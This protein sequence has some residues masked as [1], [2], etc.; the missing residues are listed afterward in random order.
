MKL[1]QPTDGITTNRGLCLASS[2]LYDVQARYLL[3]DEIATGGMAS[4]H[5]GRSTERGGPGSVVAIKQMHP[6]LARSAE[7]VAMFLDE[8]RMVARIRHPNVVPVV[9]VVLDGGQLL[10]VMKLVIGE[11]L[12]RLIAIVREPVPPPIAV[13]IV[14]DMLRGLHAA[15]E[16]TDEA[17]APLHIVHRDVSPQ[18]VMV[19]IDGVARVLDFGIAK[20]AGRLQTTREGQI[21]GKAAYMAPEQLRGEEEVDRR[22]DVYAAATLLWELLT[23]ERLFAATSMEEKVT[24]ILEMKV[25]PPSSLVPEISPAID[26]VVLRGLARRRE[27]RWT[28]AEEMEHA[29]AGA[30]Q[31]ATPSDVA[32]W[33]RLLAGSAISERARKVAEIESLDPRAAA[34]AP[35]AA[36]PARSRASALLLVLGA[37][38]GGAAVFAVPALRARIAATEA[39]E[40]ARASSDAATSAPPADTPPPEVPSVVSAS[41]PSTPPSVA[42]SAT[43]RGRSTVSP[44]RS[45]IPTIPTRTGGSSTSSAKPPPVSTGFTEDRHDRGPP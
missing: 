43:A 40:A 33:V 29:L 19:G 27:R 5:L 38:I 13:A 7:F 9:D 1:G 11:P 3:L 14:R 34:P 39:K 44:R 26:A 20:A 12:S 18:N 32:A 45:A 2:R 42:T 36:A 21:K 37:A 17:G 31:A 10:L 28:T 6:H 41:V 35:A 15:H 30:I 8:A 25:P 4:V 23:G 16:A 24:K 22:T